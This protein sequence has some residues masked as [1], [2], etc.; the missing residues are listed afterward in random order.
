MRLR[1]LLLVVA[2]SGMACG[3]AAPRASTPTTTPSVKEVEDVGAGTPRRAEIYAAVIRQLVTVDHTFGAA[4]PRF[5]VVYVVDGVVPGAGSSR[6]DYFTPARPFGEELTAGI[7]QRLEG[8]V[9]PIRFVADGE[10]ALRSVRTGTVENRGVLVSLGPIGRKNGRVR[11]P[12][13]L[14]CGGKCA[15]WMTY[16]LAERDGRWVVT[17]S[18]PA[19][20]S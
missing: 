1:L 10:D 17:R 6:R 11:V 20:I 5:R 12:N 19:T 7:R 15:Q 2:V 8:E 4:Q 18:G 16:V 9:P 13:M 14:W 3:D